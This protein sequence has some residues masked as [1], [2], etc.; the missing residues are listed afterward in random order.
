MS[1]TVRV[2]ISD[3]YYEHEQF[4]L[5]PQ[6]WWS[7]KDLYDI[8]AEQLARW[9]AAQGAWQDAQQEMA[10]L[11]KERGDARRAAQ[12]ARQKREDARRVEI[13]ADLYGGRKR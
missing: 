9:E 11:M 7:D 8:P 12:A 1:D 10:A 4:D 2:R 3:G 6:T 5:I 13:R